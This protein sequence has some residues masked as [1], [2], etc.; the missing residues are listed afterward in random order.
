MARKTQAFHPITVWAEVDGRTQRFEVHKG[1]PSRVYK[2]SHTSGALRRVKEEKVLVAVAKALRK[3][4]DSKREAE[5]AE[6]KRKRGRMARFFRWVGAL[7]Y[8]T[9]HSVFPSR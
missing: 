8:R 1:T 5:E 2:K 7:A 3:G 4:V 9:W 6:L